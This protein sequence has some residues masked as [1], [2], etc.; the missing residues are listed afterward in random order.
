M[1]KPDFSSLNL[2]RLLEDVLGLAQLV[3]TEGKTRAR[4]ELEKFLG[5]MDFVTRKEFE[6]VKAIAVAARMQAEEVADHV[7]YKKR[8]TTKRAPAKKVVRGKKKTK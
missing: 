8:K 4:G 7:G 5:R 1:P 3:R 6:A 2:G